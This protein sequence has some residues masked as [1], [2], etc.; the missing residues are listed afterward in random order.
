[1]IAI[2]SIVRS[3]LATRRLPIHY[4]ME[5]LHYA[6]KC[7][8]ELGYDSKAIINIKV[9]ELTVD[10]NLEVARP[11]DYVDV[12]RMGTKLGNFILELA[13]TEKLNRLQSQYDALGAADGVDNSDYLGDINSH[14]EDLGG[15]Y[16]RASTRLDS[17]QEIR[18][19]GVFTFPAGYLKEGDT[20]YLEYLSTGLGATTSFVHEYASEAVEAYIEM[21]HGKH[22]S[23]R[24]EYQNARREFHNQRRITRA[25]L[26]GTT[27]IDI[28]RALRKGIKQSVKL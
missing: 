20:V 9:V 4:Y 21:M 7:V 24:L 27:I 18:E 28:K 8:K 19:R 22:R 10:A 16:G 13:S 12:I 5:F 2:D 17:Y 25:R 3:A 14:G 15:Q 11:S 26:S 23:S 6:L 1:M